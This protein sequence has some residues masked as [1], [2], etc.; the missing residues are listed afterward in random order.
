MIEYACEEVS[1]HVTPVVNRT[2]TLRRLY[3]SPDV[4]DRIA[5]C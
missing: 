2:L 3:Q 4:R 1:S 5:R